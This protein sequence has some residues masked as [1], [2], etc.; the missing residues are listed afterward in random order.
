MA[1]E[2]DQEMEFEDVSGE[3]E[4][5]EISGEEV[6][7]I[8]ESLEELIESAESENIKTYLEDALNSIYYLVHDEDEDADAEADVDELED[9]L[10]EPLSEAA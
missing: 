5:E 9:E 4:F 3:E 8:V 1:E 6:D 7:R 10:D 2:L